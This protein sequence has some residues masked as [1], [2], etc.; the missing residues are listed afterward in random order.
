MQPCLSS[1]RQHDG[2]ILASVIAWRLHIRRPH[3]FQH[4]KVPLYHLVTLTIVLTGNPTNSANRIVLTRAP[5]QERK[6]V[7]KFWMAG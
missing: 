7:Y 4:D 6:E 3:F 5:K 2:Y 1:A